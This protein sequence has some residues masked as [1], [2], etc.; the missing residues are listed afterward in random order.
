MSNERDPYKTRVR[1]DREVALRFELRR[2]KEQLRMAEREY[3]QAENGHYERWLKIGSASEP[4]TVE[5]DLS[6]ANSRLMAARQR[7]QEALS[8]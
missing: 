1:V 5:P 3:E 4:R 8:A 7:Y 6:A 2:S